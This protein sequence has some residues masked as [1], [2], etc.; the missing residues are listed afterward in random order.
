MDLLAS[1][2]GRG[3]KPVVAQGTIKA[4]AGVKHHNEIIDNGFVKVSIDH[5]IDPKDDNIALPIP[6]ERE[7]TS[8]L[9]EA[10]GSFVLWPVKSM[11]H[12]IADD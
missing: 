11:K 9:I 4:L 7:G 12:T 3:R 5:I 1:T 8:L 2:G 10:K 6:D